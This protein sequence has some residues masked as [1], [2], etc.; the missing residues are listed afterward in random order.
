MQ[1][2]LAHAMA[3]FALP[4]A[5]FSLAGMPASAQTRTGA[6][7]T[8]GT[9]SQPTPGQLLEDFLHYVLI[10]RPDVAAATGQSLLDLNVDPAEFVRIVEQSRGGLDRFNRAVI[11]AQSRR[12][13]EPT[14]SAILKT[15]ENGKLAVARDPESIA[16]NIRD[17]TGV[18]RQA[19]FAE[20]RLKEAGEYALPQLLEAL[21][22]RQDARLSAEARRIM[23]AMGR[24][25]V[26][27]LISAL[28]DLE[29]AAQEL[30][31]GILGDIPYPH[32]LPV[33]YDV[34]AKSDVASVRTSIEQAIRKIVGV[35]NDSTP[36]ADRYVEVAQGYY[37]E[38]PSLTP[39]PGE[40][41][42]LW[43]NHDPR[44]GLTFD[45]IDTS[46]FH[47]AMAMR[48]AERALA[49]DG[50]NHRAVA[51]WLAS[52]FSREID[53]PE[54]YDNPAYPP[55]RREAMYY[56]V[57]SGPA[58][59]QRVLARAIDDID[60]PLARRAIESI[61][62]TAGGA[63]LWAGLEGR[64]PLLEALRYSN[65][66]VQ[67]DAAIALANAQPTEPFDGSDRVVPILASA[68]RD[69]GTKYAAVIAS[70]EER[71]SS[72]S[73]ILQGRGFTVLPASPSLSGIEQQI[74]DAPAVDLI[75]SDLPA[76][77]TQEL[78]DE[79]RGRNKL[80]ATPILALVSTQGFDELSPRFARDNSVRIAKS[81]LTPDEIIASTDD[82]LDRAIGGLITGEEA[83]AYRD[84]ALAALRDLGVS[85]NRVLNVA[86]AGGPLITALATA[87]GQTRITIAEVLSHVPTSAAQQAI[88]DAAMR[89]DGRD[90]VELLARASG[91]AK[92]HGN[93]LT[94]RHVASLLRL[95]RDGQSEE[96]TAAAALMGSLNLPNVNVVPLILGQNV[97]N[98]AAADVR[99]R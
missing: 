72:L 21:L 42:Q 45:A 61:D 81:G 62:K 95:V 11:R 91:S 75:V 8:R 14:A 80:R 97:E 6:A 90:R 94:D 68:I 50:T 76:A 83:R 89:A 49:L 9:T 52:N 36:V 88:F 10:D 28:P 60:T 92:R 96:A 74:A 13:L 25:S 59:S 17:L 16:K 32:S 79:S 24:H 69:V 54:N 44:I 73:S 35:L 66:R 53:G 4:L 2:S 71:G 87:T 22:Q 15:Y 78:I 20:A 33:L 30:V 3:S 65:R 31:A 23:V 41:N 34:R 98:A 27:P 47:E 93:Q 39:F 86:D 5:L 46:V 26:V 55:T 38:S 58:A 7:E 85:G 29:P 18:R 40:P 37:A 64:R 99:A 19:V 57:A 43:W 82:L 70:S 63:G 84:S 67:Y 12:E 1:R 48:F 77:S 56:A 51:T